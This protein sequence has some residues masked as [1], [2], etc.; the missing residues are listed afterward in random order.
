MTFLK[1]CVETNLSY[2]EVAKP[3]LAFCKKK[4][5]LDL[6]IALASLETNLS[7]NEVAKCLLAF[8]KKKRNSRPYRHSDC[9]C[10][11]LAGQSG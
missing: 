2:N 8:C 11:S 3:L 4:G 1:Y 7:Y 9:T 6:T 10:Q 5:V